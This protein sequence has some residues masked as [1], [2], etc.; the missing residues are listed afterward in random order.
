MVSL[1]WVI[2]VVRTACLVLL[3]GLP[4]PAAAQISPDYP[5][6]DSPAGK[7]YEI[8]L[9][10]GRR[11]AAPAPPGRSGTRQAGP[12]STLRS[13]NGFG[14]SAEVPAAIRDDG[15][16]PVADQPFAEPPDGRSTPPADRSGSETG[17]ALAPDAAVDPPSE[18]ASYALVIALVI[19]GIALGLAANSSAG[20]SAARRLRP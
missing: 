13:E 12:E 9:E 2:R 10:G 18:A 3:I 11:D 14:S 16:A 8:P 4:V 19:G 17:R 7:I 1:S 6:A 15:G 20:R 5:D